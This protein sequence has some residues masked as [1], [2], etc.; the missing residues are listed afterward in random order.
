MIFARNDQELFRI[1]VLH[2]YQNVALSMASWSVLDG[3]AARATLIANVQM[4]A[5]RGNRLIAQGFA[6]LVAFGRP[7][8]AENPIRAGVGLSIG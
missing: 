8:A 1:A 2:D 7:V 6:D 3:Q 4:D 5:E